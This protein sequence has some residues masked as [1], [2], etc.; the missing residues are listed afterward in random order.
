VEYLQVLKEV[1]P[2][3]QQEPALST[4]WDQRDQLEQALRQE[5]RG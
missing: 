4:Y 2:L 1:E 5:R 3:I